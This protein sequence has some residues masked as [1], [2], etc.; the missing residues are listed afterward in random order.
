MVILYTALTSA[1]RICK[2]FRLVEDPRSSRYH[3]HGID[4]RGSGWG[5]P[6]FHSSSPFHR[7][8]PL[9]PDSLQVSVYY[10]CIKKGSSMF[11][12]VILCH[13]QIKRSEEVAAKDL[14][15]AVKEQE[16]KQVAAAK[17]QEIAAKQRALSEAEQ[18]MRS[19]AE[20][21]ASLK[22]KL[23]GNTEQILSLQAEIQI[24]QV[25]YAVG[26]S[27]IQCMYI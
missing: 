2:V 20:N 9:N 1:C 15:I 4:R 13:F 14:Q 5:I 22:G 11:K 16:I 23:E 25:T 27:L 24:L 8:I 17:N 10:T 6:V 26:H 18:Q 3:R 12:T 7:S 21:C 19:L